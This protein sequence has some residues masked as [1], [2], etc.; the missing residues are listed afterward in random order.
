MLSPIYSFKLYIS[1]DPRI[2]QAYTAQNTK[3][4]HFS[5]VTLS[6]RPRV[7]TV[8]GSCCR[9]RYLASAVHASSHTPGSWC[10]TLLWVSDGTGQITLLRLVSSFGPLMTRVWKKRHVQF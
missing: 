8:A 10:P 3:K 5:L 4:T 7:Y 1:Q 9:Q 6:I 2:A